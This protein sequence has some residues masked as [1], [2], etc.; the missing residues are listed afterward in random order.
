MRYLTVSIL[1]LSISIAGCDGVTGPSGDNDYV[2]F[3]SDELSVEFTEFHWVSTESGPPN[4]RF[5]HDFAEG[6]A[7]DFSFSFSV[8]AADI[9][10]VMPETTYT[11]RCQG[12]GTNCL[13]AFMTLR[14]SETQRYSETGTITITKSDADG[15]EGEFDVMLLRDTDDKEF[16]Y[17]GSFAISRASFLDL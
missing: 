12:H 5:R 17:T 4:G 15:F 10:N 6:R 3:N 8:S 2:R 13:N 1:A 14:D 7:G 9:V 11:I 16:H